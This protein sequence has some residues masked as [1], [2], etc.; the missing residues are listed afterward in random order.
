MSKSHLINLC[1]MAFILCTSGTTYPAQSPEAKSDRPI[2]SRAPGEALKDLDAA[3]STRTLIG[4][5]YE[6]WFIHSLFLPGLDPGS[7]KTAE[8]VPLLVKYSSYD[9][10]VIRKHEEWFEY[11]G[12]DWLLIDWSNMLWMNPAWEE[13]KGASPR[14]GETTALLFKTYSKL[15]REGKTATKAGD[16]ARLAG[17]SGSTKIVERLNSVL[18]WTETNFLEKPE[19]KDLWLYYHGK[20]LLTVLALTTCADIAGLSKGFVASR[21]T[22]RLMGSQ[23]QDTHAEDCGFWSWM[24][25]P[26]RQEVT[27]KSGVAEETVV[28]PASFPISNTGTG[29]LDSHA[30][31]R[32]HGAP[33]LESWDVAFQSRPK[34]IQIH[35]WNEFTGQTHPRNEAQ[36]T[37]SKHIVYGDEYNLEFSDDI[38]PTRL[39]ACT[40]SGCGGWGYYYVNLTKALISLYRSQTPDITIMALSGP[41]RSEVVKEGKWPLTWKVIG[42]QPSSYTLRLDGKL[43]AGRIHGQRYTLDLANVAPGKHRVTLMANGVHTYFDLSPE[44]LTRKSGVPLPVISDIEFAYSPTPN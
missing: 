15:Q 26:I 36:G 39:D 33:Y 2:N 19:Y 30:V 9:I 42:K 34:F 25:G 22:V 10:N 18:A 41:S 5:Q 13:H 43:V 31:G 12:I 23:L 1:V 37:S 14:T 40:D 16:Y 3:S 6:T 29:W 44:K 32:D 17:L 4:L 8:A 7:R 11:L 35:Q 27:Y 20:P 38:E 28:T 21:W 24:D